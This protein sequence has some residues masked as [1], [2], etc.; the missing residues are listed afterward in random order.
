MQFL[1]IIRNSFM[2]LPHSQYLIIATWNKLWFEWR[3]SN[4]WMGQRCWGLEGKT[5]V[6]FRN[7]VFIFFFFLFLVFPDTQCLCLPTYLQIINPSCTENWAFLIPAPSQNSVPDSG[8]KFSSE[9]ERFI[10]R[11]YRPVV[12]RFQVKLLVLS[13]T[14]TQFLRD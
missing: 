5:K 12:Y 10:R 3:E 2:Y 1:K 8:N 11:S 13:C 7:E 14:S 4:F 9:V 6:F